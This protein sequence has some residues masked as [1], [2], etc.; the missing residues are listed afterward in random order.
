M[1]RPVKFRAWHIDLKEWHY[2]DDIPHL[3]CYSASELRYDY[4]HWCQYTGLKDRNG[5]EIYEGDILTMDGKPNNVE[6]GWVEGFAGWSVSERDIFRGAYVIGNIYDN[7]E[8]PVV[9]T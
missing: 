3:G 9:E 1:S 2:F 4:E 7:P 5:K 6:V 8:I